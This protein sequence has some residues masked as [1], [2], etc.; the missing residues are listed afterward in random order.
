MNAEPTLFDKTIDIAGNWSKYS[1]ELNQVSREGVSDMLGYLD[2][3]TDFKTAPA[4]TR[5][6]LCTEGGLCQHSLN[7]L[8]A[9]RELAPISGHEF[10][11]EQLVITALL[12]DICKT[13]FYYMKDAWDKE[14]K[15][16]TNQWRK[17]KVWGVNDRLPLGHGEKSAILANRHIDLTKEEMVAI[18]WHMMWSDPGVHFGYPSGFPFKE[19]LVT[20]PLLKILAIA[21]FMAE[22]RESAPDKPKKKK[23][24]EVANDMP[25]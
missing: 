21:D 2:T 12:H 23:K 6:H 24:Q 9:A 17:I 13:N 10:E 4:S 3:K 20:C 22:I 7:V 8:K 15:E 25:F 14:H 5:F 1:E 16:K 11:D 18:R 19:S